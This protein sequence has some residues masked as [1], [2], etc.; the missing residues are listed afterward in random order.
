METMFELKVHLACDAE[1]G[2]WYIAESD[3]P[4]LWLEADSPSEL[5]ARIQA[6]APEIVELNNDEIVSACLERAAKMKLP[7]PDCARPSIMPIFDSPL[8]LAYA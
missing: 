6:A 7:R 5:V 1:T 2:R 8:A 4:G 3:I